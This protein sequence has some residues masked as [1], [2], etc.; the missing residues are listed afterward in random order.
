MFEAELLQ[1]L[2]VVSD[3]DFA[4][5]LRLEES[6]RVRSAQMS[7]LPPVLVRAGSVPLGLQPPSRVHGV[8][9]VS[10]DEAIFELQEVVRMH[11]LGGTEVRY[12][13]GEASD[14]SD[15]IALFIGSVL[16]WML[17]QRGLLLLRGSAIAW[18]DG[19]VLIV[20][21]PAVGKSTLAAWLLREGAGLLADDLVLISFEADGTPFISPSRVPMR[22]AA[23]PLELLDLRA[24]SATPT[25][26]DLG[27]VWVHPP[28]ERRISRPC[29]FEAVVHL[30]DHR[31]AQGCAGYP[32]HGPEAVAVLLDQVCHAPLLSAP[33]LHEVLVGVTKASAH[34]TTW[35]VLRQVRDV[36][37]TAA[38]VRKVL[39]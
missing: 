26:R 23:G 39:R 6:G 24:S 21:P 36:G 34:V 12:E 7:H 4:S 9:Q 33:R 10:S 11:V 14:S 30:A 37:A 1:G 18:R 16:P 19:A 22:L 38:E 20:G 35:K 31:G 32:L 3:I 17:H 25:R 27:A 5:A 8:W 28:A 2:H 15:L 13:L 29:R